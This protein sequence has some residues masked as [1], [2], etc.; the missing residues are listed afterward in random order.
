MKTKQLIIISMLAFFATLNIYAQQTE[1][2]TAIISA[3]NTGNSS[4]LTAYLAPHIE[5]VVDDKN[6]IYSKQQASGIITDFF[7]SKRINSFNVLHKGN[8]D[9]ASFV[10]GTLK[11]ST[12]TFRVYVLT[13]KQG[14][15]PLIQQLRIESTN[16]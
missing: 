9:A 7:R 1:V 11:T 12:G 16:E 8:K 13:R 14:A 2:P 4:E 10:I 3:L 15:T 6:D 5:L